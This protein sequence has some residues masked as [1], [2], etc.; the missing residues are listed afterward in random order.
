MEPSH[1]ENEL[2]EMLRS[3]DVNIL[4]R[5]SCRRY[6]GHVNGML[7]N[8]K[9]LCTGNRDDMGMCVGD[10]GSPLISQNREIVGIASWRGFACGKGYPDVYTRVYSH[11]NWIWSNLIDPDDL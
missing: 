1:D 5:K 10:V 9:Q 7:L 11:L 2:S 8:E 4:N 6:L 3:Q